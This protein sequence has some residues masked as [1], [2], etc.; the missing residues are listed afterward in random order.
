MKSYW[1]VYNKDRDEYFVGT[2]GVYGGS[3]A[4]RGKNKNL[5]PKLYNSEGRAKGAITATKI[6]NGGGWE[7]QEVNLTPIIKKE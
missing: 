7:I 4:T 1:V 6:W 3:T 2:G 5:P